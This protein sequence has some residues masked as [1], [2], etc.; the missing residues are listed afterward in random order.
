[1]L[2]LCCIVGVVIFASASHDSKVFLLVYLYKYFLPSI[3]T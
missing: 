3:I 2:S 1:L